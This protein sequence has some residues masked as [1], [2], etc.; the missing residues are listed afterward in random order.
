V[1]DPLVPE[2]HLPADVRLSRAWAVAVV[3]GDEVA[4]FLS[5]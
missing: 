5:E 4:E 1:P 3:E 2:V